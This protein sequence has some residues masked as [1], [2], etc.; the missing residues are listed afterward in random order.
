[1]DGF[2]VRKRTAEDD[3]NIEKCTKIQN[4]S[5]YYLFLIFIIYIIMS[6]IISFYNLLLFVFNFE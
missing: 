1:M 5:N 2:V 6:I 3:E 4:K